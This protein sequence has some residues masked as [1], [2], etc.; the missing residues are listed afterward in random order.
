MA[1]ADAYRS[2]VALPAVRW[3]QQNLDGLGVEKRIA[4][5]AQIEAVLAS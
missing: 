2:Q 5:V 3:R 1:F 4:L